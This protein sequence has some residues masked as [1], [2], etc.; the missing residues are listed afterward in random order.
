MRKQPRSIHKIEKELRR[1]LKHKDWLEKN[2]TTSEILR[3][4]KKKI[5]KLR[6]ELAFKN[7]E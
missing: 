6:T 2:L 5:L 7:I 3:N 4:S 1:E